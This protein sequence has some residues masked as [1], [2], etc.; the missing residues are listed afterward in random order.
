MD[1]LSLILLVPSMLCIGV[2][3]VFTALSI[4]GIG[5]AICTGSEKVL[6]ALVDIFQ[7]ESDAWK[8]MLYCTIFSSVLYILLF[9]FDFLSVPDM[10]KGILFGVPN[11]ICCWYIIWTLDYNWN[12]RK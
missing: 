5:H 11:A 3:V 9:G 1:T 4:I 6:H 12:V 2:G 7:I 8:C 10:A